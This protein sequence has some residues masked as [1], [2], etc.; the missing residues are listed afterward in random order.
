MCQDIARARQGH[1]VS[2]K[3]STHFLQGILK[4]SDFY[5]HYQGLGDKLNLKIFFSDCLIF[6]ILEENC[7]LQKLILDVKIKLPL[8]KFKYVL[9]K[10]CY[11]FTF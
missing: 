4:T 10:V 7:A 11:L 5:P 2:T 3:L 1:I 8:F 6:G 9:Y